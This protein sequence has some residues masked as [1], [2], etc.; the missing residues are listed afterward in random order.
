MRKISGSSSPASTASSAAR[1]SR[2]SK[3][4]AGDEHGFGRFVEP[5]VGAP[6]PLQEAR[7]SLGR[8]HLDHA[9]DIP[10]VDAQIEAGGGDQRAQLSRRHRAFHLAP[11]L[12]RQAAVM[13][14]DRQ[15]HRVDLP[16]VLEDQL[17]QAT[18]VAEHQR[19][20][21]RLD[22]GHHLFGGIAARV[23]RPRHAAL[24]QQDI[25]PGLG[26]RLAEHQRN[27]IDI[28]IRREPCAI[29]I[30][31]GDRRR[32]RDAAHGRA[33]YAWSRAMHKAEQIAALA[34]SRRHALRRPR[35]A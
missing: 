22:L 4:V 21:M 16:Q 2:Y 35:S 26:S 25:D 9:I 19:R 1:A 17:G 5:V 34:A 32:Q 8:A 23:A 10:P 13:D 33:R 29:P 12:A 7:R 18:R 24:G 14:A 30:G 31:I 3:R 11:R 15:P 28:A 27:A 6:D 20:A